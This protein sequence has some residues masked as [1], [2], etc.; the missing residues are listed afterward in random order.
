MSKRV[1]VS[2]LNEAEYFRLLALARLTRSYG[3][4]VPPHVREGLRR[5][6]ELDTLSPVAQEVADMLLGST[7]VPTTRDEAVRALKLVKSA[8]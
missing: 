7:Q 3:A 6:L 8:A 4:Q 1:S 5:R 2:P